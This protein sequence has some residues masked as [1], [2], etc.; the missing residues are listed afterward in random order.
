MLRKNN[1]A[2]DSTSCVRVWHQNINSDQRNSSGV[3][4]H[5]GQQGGKVHSLH[6]LQEVGLG[7]S[8][9]TAKSRTEE[10][11][12]TFD[13]LSLPTAQCK[14]IVN[15]ACGGRKLSKG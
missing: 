12:R 10:G 8:H 11:Y 5:G 2:A 6:C 9:I 1:N 13:A 4:H 14:L 7:F 15:V 3:E